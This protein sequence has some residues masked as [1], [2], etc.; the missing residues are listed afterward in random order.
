[1]G[2]FINFSLLKCQGKLQDTFKYALISHVPEKKYKQP[3]FSIKT[4]SNALP[5]NWFCG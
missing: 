5:W 2:V 3:Y 1:M 4:V